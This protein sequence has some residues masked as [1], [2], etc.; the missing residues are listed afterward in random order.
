MFWIGLSLQ[1]DA[2]LKELATLQAEKQKLESSLRTNQQSSSQSIQNYQ[3][4]DTVLNRADRVLGHKGFLEQ[5]S[6]ERY[7]PLMFVA[8]E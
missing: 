5:L 2:A 1:L 4:G 3:V 6:C 8:I 7:Y